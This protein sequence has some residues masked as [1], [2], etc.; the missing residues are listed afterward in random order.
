MW[1]RVYSRWKRSGPM[2]WSISSS[3]K[4]SQGIFTLRARIAANT[5]RSPPYDSTAD[6]SKKKHR[7][8][9]DWT[10]QEQNKMCHFQMLKK[11]PTLLRLP[12]MQ[13]NCKLL[14]LFS[15]QLSLLI[16]LRQSHTLG[17]YEL[18]KLIHASIS[19]LNLNVP[20]SAGA[21]KSLLGARCHEAE[22]HVIQVT[23]ALLLLFT[24]LC[25][26]LINLASFSFSS[27]QAAASLCAHMVCFGDVVCRLLCWKLE[28]T[29][30]LCC[31]NLCQLCWF[32]HDMT[33]CMPLRC[34]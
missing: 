8:H 27:P 16:V 34:I 11:D 29:A 28:P 10:F 1:L 13:Y 17:I 9:L 6:E 5:T 22:I 33:G 25:W 18:Y 30:E 31:Q 24:A 14:F 21:V 15:H 20:L 2:I 32:H 4:H 23:T 26:H 12:S 3:V 7:Y 19:H